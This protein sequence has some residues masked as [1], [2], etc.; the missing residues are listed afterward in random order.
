MLNIKRFL[1]PAVIVATFMIVFSWVF[2]AAHSTQAQPTSF[3]IESVDYG[4]DYYQNPYSSYDGYV[5]FFY[6]SIFWFIFLAIFWPYRALRQHA[7]NQK[8]LWQTGSIILGAS[9]ALAI[10]LAWSPY[11]HSLLA[12][13]WNIV[14]ILAQ[15]TGAL[16]AYALGVADPVYSLFAPIAFALYPTYLL[17]VIFL[18]VLIKR[19][20]LTPTTEHP[21][22]PSITMP[23]IWL[24]LL[25]LV[26]LL[27]YTI[28]RIANGGVL[29][30]CLVG[31]RALQPKPT[32]VAVPITHGNGRVCR[33]AL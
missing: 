14:H 22:E 20:R 31:L 4:R 21:G 8:S 12:T 9:S 18:L 1:R 33:A 15:F 7:P 2:M 27:A 24:I 17:D 30:C 28:L 16:P 5:K 29:A 32:T 6:L 25:G 10:I 13:G 19:V 23:I 3:S 26:P 11:H